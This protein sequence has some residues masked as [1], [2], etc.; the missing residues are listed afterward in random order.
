MKF[1]AF[2][3]A[4]AFFVLFFNRKYNVNDENHMKKTKTLFAYSKKGL[5]FDYNLTASKFEF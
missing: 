1:P 4:N 3:L 2:V 5:C